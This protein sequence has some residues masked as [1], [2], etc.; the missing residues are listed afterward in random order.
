MADIAVRVQN[1]GKEYQLGR[2][3]SNDMIRDAGGPG[4]LAPRSGPSSGS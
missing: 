2:P 3:P 4:P 1:L